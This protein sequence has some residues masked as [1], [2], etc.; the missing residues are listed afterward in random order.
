VQTGTSRDAAPA[1]SVVVLQLPAL[2]LPRQGPP[3]AV[4]PGLRFDPLDAFPSGVPAWPPGGEPVP[5]A[6]PPVRPSLAADLAD[7][8]GGFRTAAEI[9]EDYRARIA[10][11]DP[12]LR[13]FLTVCPPD[14]PQARPGPGPLHGAAVALKDI[15]ETADLET[16]GGSRLRAGYLPRRDATCWARLRAA[17]ALCLGKTNLTEFA[18]GPTGENDHYGPTRNPRDPRR[19]AGGSS[20]GS[21]AAVA[22]GLCGVALGTDT[23][24]SVRI[25]AACCGVVGL[26]P[27][28]GR[29]S[30][31]GVFPLSWS[32]DHVG[33][34]ARTV[35]DAALCL[36]AM[37]G[38]D[39]ED[40]TT[41]HRPPL[42]PAE[43]LGLPR[44]TGLRGLRLGVPVGWL[45]EG[46][47]G[48]PEAPATG[49]LPTADAVRAAFARVLDVCRA[50]GAEVVEVDLG[51]ADAATAV[52]RLIALPESAAYHQPDLQ[53]RPEAFG[54]RVR[55][56]LLSGR[57]V[58]AETYLQAL[59]LRTQLCRRYAEVLTG[60]RGVQLLVTPTLP[61]VAP[62]LG[63]G[64]AEALALLRFCAP[65]N[66]VGWPAITLPCGED[67]DGLPVGVQLAAGPFREPE[68]LG[69]AAAL[70]AAL[71]GG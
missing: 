44:P 57:L 9:A 18:A 6:V 41:W 59:R 29:V 65:F 52:N 24:G 40:P 4:E 23:G 30:R 27:T 51:S 2:L 8:A 31:A 11:L 63:C 70:E 33:P 16:T 20:G 60:P 62:P 17:G 56:R 21:A 19:V 49:G 14:H 28:Y 54:P 68:L 37:A 71:R 53:A 67:A 43:T 66:V 55:G 46:S 12:Q 42:P 10:A 1:A 5:A 50:L 25:P 45:E 7:A 22:A 61:T 58:Q 32:L 15:L 35:R 47:P 48:G 38:S 26:K 64:P 34:I 39:P 36:H 69:A 13:A 3:A